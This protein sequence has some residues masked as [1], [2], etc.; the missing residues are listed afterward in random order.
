MKTISITS[1]YMPTIFEQIQSQL[2]GELEIKS[3]E[4]QL[5]IDNDIAKG[6]ISGFSVEHAISYMEYD[7]VFKEDVIDIVFIIILF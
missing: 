6:I 4:Y 5:E 7:I 1:N 3:K 2:G